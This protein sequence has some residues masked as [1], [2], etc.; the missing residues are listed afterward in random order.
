MVSFNPTVLRFDATAGK[1]YTVEHKNRLTDPSWT[2]VQSVPSG[3]ARP[4]Q[5][6]NSAAG[7]TNRFYRVR[8]P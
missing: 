4:V 5:V 6:T 2:L 7:T 8:T 1:A 3:A